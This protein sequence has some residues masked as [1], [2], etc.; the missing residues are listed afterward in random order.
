ML[1]KLPIRMPQDLHKDLRVSNIMNDTLMSDFLSEALD[2]VL[3]QKLK[4]IVHKPKHRLTT[5]ILDS[6]MI[7][8]STQYAKDREV[9]MNSLICLAIEAKLR[10]LALSQTATSDTSDSSTPTP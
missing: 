4:V 8:R 5:V 1:V 3:S 7:E 9:S 2:E 10:S 6:K